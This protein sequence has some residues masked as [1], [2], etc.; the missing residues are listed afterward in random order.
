MREI[1]A[2]TIVNDR[3]VVVYEYTRKKEQVLR[4]RTPPIGLLSC[5]RKSWKMN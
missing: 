1:A 2:I 5:R 3:G 4:T